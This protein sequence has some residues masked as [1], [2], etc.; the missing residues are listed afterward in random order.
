MKVEIWSDI[1]CPWCYVGKRRFEEALTSF[2]ATGEPVEIDWKS[3]ELDPGTVSSPVGEPADYAGRLGKK[4]GT[5]RDQAAKM[6]DSM[7]AT[8]AEVGLDFHFEKAVP[9]NTFDAHQLVHLGRAHGLQQEVKD[10]LLQAHFSDGEAV[11]DRETL[12]R[13]GVEAGLDA[14]EIRAALE[15]QRYA[16]AVR[17]DEAEAAELGV[18]G[19]PFFVIDRRYGI[20]G[21][22]PAAVFLQALN[23]AQA[24]SR[25]LTMVSASAAGGSPD[26]ADESCGPDGCA[27]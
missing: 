14:D 22:Q 3:F 27:V 18:S 16:A 15:D 23:R 8:A 20:S 26:A 25:A 17:A 13:L 6:L 19:V 1:A 2:A 7:T 11:G 4:F 24:D 21:A 10:R 5:S 12:V 9:A